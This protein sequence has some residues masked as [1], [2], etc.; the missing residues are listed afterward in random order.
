LGD[1]KMKKIERRK[2]DHIEVTLEEPISSIHNYW[3][4]IK[5]IHNS[6]PE[7]N[8]DDIDTSTT[9]FGK[10]LAF[11]LIVT[12]ITGGYSKAEKINRNISEACQ[13][14]RI[15]M[16]IGSQRAALESSEETSY[17]VMKDYDIPLKIGNVGAPQLVKQ[18]G[19]EPMSKAELKRAV[20]MVDADLL[21]IHLN[22]LQ[23]MVQSE[24][25]ANA[26][27]CLNAIREIAKEFPIL[28]K[29]TGAGI[30]KGVATRLKGT[31]I[32]GIDV[33]GT[34]G[35]SFSAVEMYR[36]E[37]MGD[38]RG[39]TLGRTLRDWGIPSPVCVIWANVGLPLIASGGITNGVQMAKGL[40]LGAKCGGTA[41]SV[42]KEALESP[43]RVEEKLVLML[44]EFKVA[45][46]LTGSKSV[47][48]L[49]KRDYIITG[50]VKDWIDGISK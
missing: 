5:L 20:D 39:V 14:L 6:L 28:V 12:A 24:G 15:G 10:K 38:A 8:V 31:G 44:E 33:S 40:V 26:S 4:D 47:D 2:A 46:F 13:N 42:L 41:R 19:K 23:E 11:P 30:S 21:G 36:S 35:T 50:S 45:M 29:E 18:K 16:G 3:D 1:E 34:G 25:D 37:R 9:I 22:F 17:S 32:R 27:G 49:G 48:E 7:L 43:K